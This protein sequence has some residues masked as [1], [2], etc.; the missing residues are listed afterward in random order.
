MLRLL[1]AAEQ[2]A[3]D[4]RDAICG[5]ASS[6][7]TV[8]AFDVHQ[9]EA[10]RV[11]QLVAE[12]AVALAA[13]EVEVERAVE[14]RERREREAHGI[15]AERRDAVG[16]LLARALARSTRPG[17]GP[18]CSLVRFA[19]SVS[20]STPSMRSSGSSTLPF[21]FDILLPFLVAHDG[22]D[23]DVAERHLAG[24]VG[25]RHDHARDPEEDDV[26]AGDQHRRRQERRAAP[27]CR[28]GQP[29]VEWHHSAEREPR[30]EHVLVAARTT[31]ARGRAS[32]SPARAPPLRRARRTTL[33]SS[34]YHAGIWWPHHSW[35]E[36]HQS[37]M[38]LIQCW[39][40]EIHS[41]GHEAHALAAAARRGRPASL[42]AARQRSW[43]DLPGKNGCVAGAGLRHRDEPLVGQHRLDDL[44]G[45]SAA[46]HDH[47]VRL[48]RDDQALRRRDRRAPPCA[49]RSDRGRD[50]SRAR[51]R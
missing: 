25:R 15:G 1:Q 37:W 50:I 11:P 43:I 31:R 22:V 38:L 33:P 36:M 34:S 9:H 35:R 17:A 39:Y 51:C 45:A 21:D 3:V 14:R 41:V 6:S 49:R 7:P 13:V 27:S 23:V 26:E 19:T 48:L 46:R 30:V 32:R 10:R 18:S 12:V 29:S 42:T 20:T 40:V 28:S 2:P 16:K 8:L 4:E 44:A 47:L 5:S 24:E